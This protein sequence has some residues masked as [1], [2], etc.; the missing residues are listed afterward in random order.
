MKL[1]HPVTQ[2]EFD[3]PSN[4]N[5]LS[6][7]N[8]KGAITYINQDFLSVAGFSTDELLGMNHNLVRHP[9]MPPAA[10]KDM[11]TTIQSGES[12]MGL[13]KNRCK[14]GDHYWV[15]AFATAIKE[16]GQTTEY[17]SVRTKPDRAAVKRA[18]AVYPGLIKDQL[19]GA[20][21]RPQL[22][23]HVKLTLG[24]VIGFLPLIGW[25]LFSH[26]EP[27]LYA[28]LA[29]S[30]GL[31][32]VVGYLLT[33][34][35][36]GL[37]AD[38]KKKYH[39]PLMQ[40]IFTGSMDE[41]SQIELAMKKIS[42]ELRAVVARVNDSSEKVQAAGEISVVDMRANADGAHRQQDELHQVATAVDEMSASIE[43]VAGHVQS[44]A[45]AASEAHEA[46]LTGRTEVNRSFELIHQLVDEVNNAT[47]QITEL[48]RHSASIESVLVVIKSV[49]D[50]T[51]LLALNA[52][53]EAARAGEAG[54]GFAVVA[55]EVR[56]L[57]RRTQEST[58]EIEQQISSLQLGVRQSVTA[59]QQV[60]EIS[61]SSVEDMKR[62]GA[63]FDQ[64]TQAMSRISD[65]GL[66]VASTTEEQ[67]AVANE[68]SQNINQVNNLSKENMEASNRAVAASQEFLNQAK[69]QQGLIRQFLPR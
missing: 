4:Y 52:A 57:A 46:A 16:D 60:Q 66:Q 48:D 59:M 34:R 23:L 10:F 45:Q 3:Y 28:A 67:S 69:Q 68:I 14:N 5:I 31:S 1:N 44:T 12:W 9:D 18:E 47:H 51:N 49:A 43:D 37:A 64:I 56:T 19:P 25:S 50:Q 35:L 7:T 22:S 24:T 6:T 39:N 11:W 26:P 36:R 53:I 33:S 20:L 38:A 61:K 32:S 55:D 41:V 17:Q 63:V 58:Q 2:R 62:T 30:V 8:L 54:R 15:E 29:A 13:I 27:V 42:A 40:Y 65:M 21:K